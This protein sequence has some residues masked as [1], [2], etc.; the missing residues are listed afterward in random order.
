MKRGEIVGATTLLGLGIGFFTK[1]SSH[2]VGSL[3][4]GIGVGLLIDYITF[5]VS[6]RK[7]KS[8]S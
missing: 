3:L 5:V 7:K 4:I 2:F 8:S 1:S 6:E